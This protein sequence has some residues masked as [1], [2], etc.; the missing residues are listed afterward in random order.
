M[1]GR[2]ETTRLSEMDSKALKDYC[3]LA[4]NYELMSQTGETTTETWSN[5]MIQWLK[6]KGF[7]NKRIWQNASTYKPTKIG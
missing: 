6:A 3:G 1:L 2:N 4:S 5:Q 7:I